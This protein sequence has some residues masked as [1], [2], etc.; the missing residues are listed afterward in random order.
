MMICCRWTVSGAACVLGGGGSLGMRCEVE[1]YIQVR[2]LD[3][4]AV[5]VQV[6]EGDRWGDE[7]TGGVSRVRYC[8]G[9]DDFVVVVVDFVG[10]VEGVGDVVNDY[11]EGLEG[12]V[13]LIN[14]D[15]WI[16]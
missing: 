11:D 8:E 1:P 12:E 10:V 9:D 6:A 14:V 2:Q 4:V 15:L 7:H 13:Y 3:D 16:L 5:A